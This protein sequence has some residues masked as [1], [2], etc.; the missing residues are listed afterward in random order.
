MSL[1]NT[2]EKGNQAL[3]LMVRSNFVAQGSTLNAWC[4]AN[5]V[6]IQNVREAFFGTW[7]GPR[8]DELVLRVVEAAKLSAK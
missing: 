8:A 3:Y 6:H 2:P 7:R 4:R 5:G 1:S